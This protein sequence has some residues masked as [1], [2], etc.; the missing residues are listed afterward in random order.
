MQII[1]HTTWAPERSW[2]IDRNGRCRCRK[3]SDLIEKEK[4]ERGKVLTSITRTRN[5]PS[6]SRGGLPASWG[7]CNGV[8]AGIRRRRFSRTERFDTIA[9]P[10]AVICSAKYVTDLVYNRSTRFC[11][12]WKIFDSDIGSKWEVICDEVKWRALDSIGNRAW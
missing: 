3:I 4:K 10:V 6:R 12:H 11:P 5:S 8:G 2:T 1:I 7:C 9:W